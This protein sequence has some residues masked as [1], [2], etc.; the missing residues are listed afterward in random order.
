MCDADARGS[1]LKAPEELPKGLCVGAGDQVLRKEVRGTAVRSHTNT[2]VSGES[3][4]L[5]RRS[6]SECS[7]FIQRHRLPSRCSV[8]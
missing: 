2:T 7:L 5:I 3:S 8:S 6:Y 4:Q 1:A